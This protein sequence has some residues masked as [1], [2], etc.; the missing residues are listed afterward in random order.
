MS[1]DGWITDSG[2][3]MRMN[4]AASFEPSAYYSFTTDKPLEPGTY[5][6]RV[7][8]LSDCTDGFTFRNY[9]LDVKFNYSK[10]LGK[11]TTTVLFCDGTKSTAAPME[12]ENFDPET[13]IEQCI[14]KRFCGMSRTAYKKWLAEN[15][16]RSE[17]LLSSIAKEKSNG[18]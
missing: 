16:K 11:I 14:I 1:T 13:G 6:I 3:Y 18:D 7:N 10:R 17:K 2:V 5:H 9:V 8:G 15:A 4:R 12:G